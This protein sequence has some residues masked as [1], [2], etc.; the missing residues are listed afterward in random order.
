MGAMPHDHLVTK[1]VLAILFSTDNVVTASITTGAPIF[2]VAKL[3]AYDLKLEQVDPSELPAGYKGK[4]YYW[5]ELES[6]SSDGT[7]PLTVHAGQRLHLVLDARDDRCW[8]AFLQRVQDLD[9][10]DRIDF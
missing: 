7:T 5:N 9:A 10:L 8:Q 6:D 1:D 2:K 3:V 4:V